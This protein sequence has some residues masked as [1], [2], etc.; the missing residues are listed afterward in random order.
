VDLYLFD[1][2]KTLYAYDFRK[3]LPELARVGGVSQYHLAST[4]WA[5]GYE[6]RAESGEWPTADEYLAE[7]ARVTGASLTL[8]EW[9]NARRLAMTR[10]DGSVAAVRRAASL[11]TASLLSNNPSVFQAALPI[12]AP[13]VVEA[14]G[15]N[16]LVSAGLGVRKPD[17]R[18][19]QLAMER[20]GADPEHTFFVDDSA[21]NVEG[22]A[23]I[24]IYT[25]LFTTPELLDAA[26]TSFSQRVVSSRGTA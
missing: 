10:I 6:R 22:A 18:I 16:V 19:F 25:H 12:I 26:I 9:A 14:L 5:A 8:D 13:D 7:F 4:W 21:E 2:D 11:G 3:R 23:E 20:Y 15:D 1:F 24:G 17:P